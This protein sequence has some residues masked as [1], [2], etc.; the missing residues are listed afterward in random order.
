MSI[1][2][3]GRST[4]EDVMK[5]EYGPDYDQVIRSNQPVENRRLIS[6]ISQL[7]HQLSHQLLRLFQKNPDVV[8]EMQQTDE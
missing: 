8:V 3:G 2:C 5:E 4:T 7:P 6:G 1:E